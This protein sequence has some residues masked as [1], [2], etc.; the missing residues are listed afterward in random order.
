M[1]GISG[2][3]GAQNPVSHGCVRTGAKDEDEVITKLPLFVI[4]FGFISVS[5]HSGS[6]SFILG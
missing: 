1:Q 2:N 3:F 6:V 4:R 5:I